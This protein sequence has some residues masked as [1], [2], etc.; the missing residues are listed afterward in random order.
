[1]TCGEARQ[2]IFAFLDN[3]LDSAL[4]LEVQQHLEHC[5]LCA[6]ECEIE[7]AVRRQ[8]AAKL[9][10]ADEVP[11][12]DES[13][14]VAVLRS[15]ARTPTGYATARKSRWSWKL[16]TMGAVAAVLLL[17]STLFIANRGAAP[18]NRTLADALVN[19]FTRFVSEAKPLEI[20]SADSDEVSRWL[21]ERTALAV[22]VPAVDS[23]IATLQGGR[24]C[25]IGGKSAAFAV[26]R[27]GNELASVVAMQASEESLAHMRRIDRDGHTHWVD[28]CRGHT[29]L[30]C[31]RGELVY[32]VVSRLPE[33]SI[34]LL[35]PSSDG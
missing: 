8:L 23:S 11:E 20:V 34:S 7:N 4:S 14:L 16:Q 18:G 6:R 21:Q 3:E 10:Q 22:R 15:G 12:F 13:A 9:R 31:R 25:K 24:K 19:D 2:Y 32:A 30:A 33:D 35:M 1:M 29:V 26:Y 27:I 17:A 5:P 28:Q